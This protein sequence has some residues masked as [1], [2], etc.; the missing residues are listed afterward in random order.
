MRYELGVICARL[1]PLHKGHILLINEALKQCETVYLCV[2]SATESRTGRNPFN[3]SERFVM[4]K[5]VFPAEGK[6][7]I[8]FLADIND[9]PRWPSHVMDKVID[10]YGKTPKSVVFIGGSESDVSLYKDKWETIVVDRSE[11]E[12]LSGTELRSLL[13]G[14]NPKWKEYIPVQLHEMVEAVFQSIILKNFAYKMVSSQQDID[15]EL[16]MMLLDKR[17][18]FLL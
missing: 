8:L 16:H 10:A 7:N 4:V 6:P 13:T 2:G 5:T 15:P 3:W 9:P 1:Q 11:S 17:K 14:L 18:K 12:L